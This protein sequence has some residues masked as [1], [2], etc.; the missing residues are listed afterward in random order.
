MRRTH[1]LGALGTCAMAALA[2]TPVAAVTIDYSS[3]GSSPSSYVEFDPDDT[4][5]LGATVGCFSFNPSPNIEIDSGSAAGDQGTI[6][7]T[8]EVGTIATVV[9]P[10]GPLESAPVSG[11]GTLTIN[12]GV[13]L[14]QADLTWIDIATF[15]TAGNI[16][17][18]GQANLTNFSYAGAD[19]DLL[20]LASAPVGIQTATFQFTG[21]TSL[22][23]LFT[24]NTTSTQ[25][26]F[27][28]SITAVPVPPAVWLFGSGLLGLVGIAR[29]RRS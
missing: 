17:T 2:T 19:P 8:F 20:A 21:V 16:N 28:G 9:T 25:T 6:D 4:C 29:R 15:G 13:N 14:L 1:L 12:D 5:T 7:G 24:T 27:S 26:S 23:Q 18:Q 3:I 22:T 10:F 11:A